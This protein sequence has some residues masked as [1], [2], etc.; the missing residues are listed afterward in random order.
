MSLQ[1]PI[2]SVGTLIRAMRRLEAAPAAADVVEV[3]R[4]AMSSR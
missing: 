2:V 3:H 1:M 4:L